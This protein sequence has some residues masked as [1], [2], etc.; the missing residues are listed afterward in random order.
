ML[1]KCWLMWMLL[2]IM[3]VGDFYVGRRGGGGGGG[4]C[5]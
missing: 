3:D 4:G 1:V 2:I 5:G